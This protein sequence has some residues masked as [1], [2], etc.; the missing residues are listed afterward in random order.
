MRV[1]MHPLKL[2][3][4]PPQLRE[5]DYLSY[6]LLVGEEHNEA[7]DADAQPAGGGH[8]VLQRLQKVFIYR[9]F[10]F[11]G[12]VTLVLLGDKAF[13]LFYGVVK[14]AVGVAKLDAAAGVS[15]ETLDH[16]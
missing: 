5:Q 14:L 2:L 6:G 10:F 12:T 4:L 1:V 11:I 7:V 9:P 13:P 3:P 8:A 15:L 16:P